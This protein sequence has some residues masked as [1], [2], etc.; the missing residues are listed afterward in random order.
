MNVMVVKSK[1]FYFIKEV[2]EWTGLSEQVIRKWEDRY[3]VIE[4]KRL[5]NGYRVYTTEDLITLK[6]LK[7]YRDEGKSMKEAVQLLASHH[8]F[9]D[10]LQQPNPVEE[11]PYVKEL[12][13]RGT[14]YDEESLFFILKKAN[15]EYGLDL[16]LQNTIQPFL[17]KI[18]TL[19]EEGK[20]DESQ[21]TLSS[22]AVR[23][24]LTGISRNFNNGVH[25]PHVLGI[26]LPYE[27][28]EIPIHLVLLQMKMKGWRTTMIG[29]SP[30]FSSIET[31]VKQLQ[32]QKV[33]L[34]ATTTIPFQKDKNL[35]TNLDTIA[36]KYSD[37]SFYIGG[38]GVW[39]YTR[40]FKPQY[41][42]ISTCVEDILV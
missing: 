7:D 28:H 34:S 25:A 38:R 33:I 6:Q 15:H 16:F 27:R 23:D 31:L 35:L 1:Q 17:Q 5:E 22:L 39:E 12:V 14:A 20:W 37:I 29:A 24:F 18:G 8:P 2:A 36:M 26:C 9:M 40:I 19:W 3:R 30:K 4:P 10:S 13:D 21:E 42:Q 32:P 41:L 11:S